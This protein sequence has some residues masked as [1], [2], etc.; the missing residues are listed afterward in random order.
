M[1]VYFIQSTPYV[2]DRK[3]IKKARLYFVGLAPAILAALVPDC[4]FECCLETIEDV[5]FETDADIIAILCCF[6]LYSFSVI[7]NTPS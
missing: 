3:L 1:K 7:L 4:E 6:H 2:G 5:D